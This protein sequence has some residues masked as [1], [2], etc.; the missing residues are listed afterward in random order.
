MRTRSSVL[1]ECTTTSIQT[2]PP[3][4]ETACTSMDN[5]DKN[6][7][8]ISQP[9]YGGAFFV[10]HIWMRRIQPA[11]IAGLVPA[12]F[13][14]GWPRQA[15]HGRY[16]PVGCVARRRVQRRVP[17]FAS[18]GAA[19]HVT[20]DLGPP[21]YESRRKAA[22]GRVVETTTAP[23]ASLDRTGEPHRSAARSTSKAA[24]IMPGHPQ[25]WARYG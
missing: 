25:S 24:P 19:N 20:P 23:P 13:L 3:F 9:R 17:H 6:P 10:K 11:D 22:E 1:A 14:T 8:V 16:R 7:P 18:F 5:L 12:G 15:W 21:A 2:G 4:T